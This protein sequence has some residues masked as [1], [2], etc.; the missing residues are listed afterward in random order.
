MSRKTILSVACPLTKGAKA[1][2]Q[3]I[4]FVTVA[5]CKEQPAI[6]ALANREQLMKSS[7][8]GV[9]YMTSPMV[10]SLFSALKKDGSPILIIPPEPASSHYFNGLFFIESALTFH[11]SISG[12]AHNFTLFF[13]SLAFFVIAFLLLPWA[14]FLSAI[15]S[16]A[17]ARA[18][19]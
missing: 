8:G 12:F 5:P 9:Y 16:P 17:V 1:A 14:R 7:K 13:F 3:L 10:C 11:L 19:I 15:S 4:E 18:V 6:F 2:K